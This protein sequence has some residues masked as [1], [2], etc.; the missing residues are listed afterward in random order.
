M[1]EAVPGRCYLCDWALLKRRPTKT[2]KGKPRRRPDWCRSK[3]CKRLYHKLYG[4][5]RRALEGR[6]ARKTSS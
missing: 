6:C 1:R 5:D 3:E 4:I 2:K